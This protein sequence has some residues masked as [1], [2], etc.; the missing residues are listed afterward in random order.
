MELPRILITHQK[1]NGKK[2]APN[3]KSRLSTISKTQAISS[4]DCHVQDLVVFH[5]HYKLANFLLLY[6]KQ[7]QLHATNTRDNIVS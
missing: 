3:K 2:K 7:N 4:R 5:A 6:T 1:K